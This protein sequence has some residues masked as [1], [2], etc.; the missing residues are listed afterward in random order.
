MQVQIGK[1]GVEVLELLLLSLIE[2]SAGT[3]EV[4][5]IGLDG[6]DL[7]RCHTHI[8]AVIIQVFEALE[9]FVVH[10]DRILRFGVERIE[11]LGYGNHLGRRVGFLE[12]GEYEHNLVERFGS[13]LKCYDGV[14]EGGRLGVVADLQDF[15]FLLGDACLESGQIVL[16]LDLI[17]WRD[18]VDGC[19]VLQERIVGFFIHCGCN[20]RSSGTYDGHC[21]K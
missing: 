19:V 6:A 11:L 8:V 17:E 13:I 1:I 3:H 9:Q 5:V 18:F 10:H 12:S 16:G 2:K 15:V 14:V 4:L 21:G 20:T 7:I